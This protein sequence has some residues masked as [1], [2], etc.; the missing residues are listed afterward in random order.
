MSA[1]SEFTPP[2]TPEADRAGRARA[3]L[4]HPLMQEAFAEVERDLIDR[5]CAWPEAADPHRDLRLA[6]Q[7]RA[8][9]LVQGVLAGYFQVTP[10]YPV[11]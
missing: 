1:V 9:R 11:L 2:A 7:L 8:V 10:D 4:D 5:L 3:L 6:D